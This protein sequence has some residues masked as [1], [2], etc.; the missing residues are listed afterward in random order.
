M[1]TSI[2][3]GAFVIVLMIIFIGIW[4]WAWNPRNKKMFDALADLP[5]RENNPKH[6]LGKYKTSEKLKVNH[7][8]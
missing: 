4:L 3:S 1:S 6:D 2:I 8:E 5:L 7:H